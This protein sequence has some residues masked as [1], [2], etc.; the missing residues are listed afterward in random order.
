[1]SCEKSTG[2]E[3]LPIDDVLASWKLEKQRKQEMMRQVDQY[4]FQMR[5]YVNSEAGQMCRG[6]D[7]KPNERT[8]SELHPAL[9][10]AHSIIQNLKKQ[11][12]SKA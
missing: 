11:D 12:Q 6:V 3:L 2:E 7:R 9:K 1:M 5:N 4:I 10:K 8:A